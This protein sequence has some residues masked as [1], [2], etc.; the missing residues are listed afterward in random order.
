MPLT[1][2]Q[3]AAQMPDHAAFC[4]YCGL[5]MYVAPVAE[6]AH[7]LKDSL[8]GAL[9]YLTFVPALLFLLLE[10]FKR[11]RFVRF[12]SFQSIFLTLAAVVLGFLMRLAFSLLALIPWLGFLLAWLAVAVTCIGWVILWMVVMVKALQGEKFKLPL[13]GDLAEK[14]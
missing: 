11:N 12:H 5:R 7:P 14:V 9:A 4:P 10:P 1:C 8:L 3:C 6:T 2:P 13:L